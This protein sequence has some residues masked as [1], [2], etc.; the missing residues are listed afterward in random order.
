M[1]D[2]TLK[3]YVGASRSGKGLAVKNDLVKGNYDAVLV[4]DAK[5][6]Y[7]K[8]GT[9]SQVWSRGY[10][11]SLSRQGLISAVKRLD[12]CAFFGRKTDFDYFCHAA[13][14][15]AEIAKIRNK[16]ACIVFEELA[17][18][19][20]A[21]K[22][23]EAFG[24]LVRMGLCT[25]CDIKIVSQRVAESDKTSISNAGIVHIC[26]TQ[27]PDDARY[28]SRMTG[29]PKEDIAGLLAD[30]ETGIF[31]FL[32]VDMRTNIVQKGHAKIKGKS[33]LFNYLPIKV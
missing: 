13:F 28:L 6:E 23:P 17:S 20:S 22:A 32:A 4:W 11:Q 24:D 9:G 3:Y 25:G 33:V 27:N 15:F 7:H 21:G 1:A 19:V 5:P 18:V 12:S 16:K 8:S 10:P 31:Q 2:G 30:P 29:V 14:V 26:R